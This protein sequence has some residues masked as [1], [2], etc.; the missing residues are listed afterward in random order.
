VLRLKDSRSATVAELAV[1]VHGVV[2]PVIYKRFRLTSRLDPWV[3]RLRRPAALRSWV[4]GHGL[5]ERCLPTPRPLA[6]LH[7]TRGGLVR[8]GY[9]L[10]EKVEDARDLHRFLAD[11][12]VLPS[13]ERRASLRE[14]IEQVARLVRQ[15]HRCRLS[16]RDLKASNVLLTADG[17][18]LI[19]LVGVTRHRKLGRRRKVQ[20]LARLHAS[21]WNLPLLTR[22][23]KLRFLR[24]YLQLG[25]FGRSGWKR[26]WMQVDEATR[27]KAAQ[28]QRR[29]RVLA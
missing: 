10:M 9:L 14:R 27:R 23:D 28:N 3:N 4:H 11:L 24:V 18:H 25:L 22:T 21:F 7:R 15:M 19:D 13:N 16:H 6:V 29:G 12:A 1:A 8:E 17:I 20:N 2:R 26:W 5:R